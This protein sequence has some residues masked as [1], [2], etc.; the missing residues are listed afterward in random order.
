MLSSKSN[1]TV[2]WVGGPL[3]EPDHGER[4]FDPSRVKIESSYFVTFPNYTHGPSWDDK[5]YRRNKMFQ[6]AKKIS[7]FETI[8]LLEKVQILSQ[9]KI[10]LSKTR[11]SVLLYSFDPEYSKFRN[12]SLQLGFCGYK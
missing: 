7:K 6:G 1:L 11:F 3:Q 4:H 10:F 8:E 2:L 5:T 9:H 12:L